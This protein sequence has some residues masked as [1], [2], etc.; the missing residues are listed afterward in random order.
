[1]SDLRIGIILGSTRPGRNGDQVARWVLDQAAKRGTATYELV[2]L[3][4]FQLPNIDEVAHPATGVYAN[5]GTQRW[6][7]TVASYDGY[8]IV[9]P[10]YNHSTSGA[11][12]NA[13]DFVYREWN[14]KA[15]GFVGYGAMGG[16]RAV[17][18]LRLIAGELKMADVRQQVGVSLMTDFENRSTMKPVPHLEPGLEILLD[19]VES[20]SA[21]LR[22]V[23]AEALAA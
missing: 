1:M 18:H 13:L 5:A 6:S 10:E 22:P 9:T 17:E 23:R 7:E 3:A 11:L 20:W 19:Q 14:D 21:A 8:V 2:D 15:V 16:Q 4:D 12:K